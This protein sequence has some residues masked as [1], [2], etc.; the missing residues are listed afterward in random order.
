LK[1]K[2][3]DILVA[4]MGKPEY[5]KAEW[6]KKGAVVMDVGVNIVTGLVFILPLSLS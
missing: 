2:Q 1:V 6:L 5:I 3:A 4:A